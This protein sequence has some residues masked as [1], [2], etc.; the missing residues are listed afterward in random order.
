MRTV[1]RPRRYLSRHL[2]P[3]LT[4]LF[5]YSTAREAYVLRVVGRRMGPVLRFDRRGPSGFEG[6]ERRNG[7][8]VA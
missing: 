5:R 4:P 8:S 2:K 6:V 3:F 7:Q 1:R